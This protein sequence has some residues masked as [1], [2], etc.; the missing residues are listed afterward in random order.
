MHPIYV[1]LF[2]ERIQTF[3]KDFDRA[4]QTLYYDESSEKLIHPGEFGSYREGLVRDLLRE[5]IPEIYGVSHGFIISPNGETSK[6]CDVVVYHKNHAPVI[7]NPEHQ[8]FF[9][10]ES[11]VAV[12]E[13]KSDLTPENL[14]KTISNL[15]TIKKYRT[16]I[17]HPAIAFQRPFRNLKYEPLTCER[18]QIGTF[19]LCSKIDLSEE[20]LLEKINEF[21]DHPSFRI[22]HVCTLDGICTAYQ[23]ENYIEMYPT[24]PD[25]PEQPLQATITTKKEEPVSPFFFFINSLFNIVRSTTVLNPELNDYLDINSNLNWSTNVR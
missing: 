23:G 13:I 17:P 19:L 24:E 16:N 9:T 3:F 20:F 21:S 12:G 18:D 5:M 6:Q 22:N 8:R 10:V 1:S 11:V 15:S 2:K 25:Y 4:S 14:R 7:R